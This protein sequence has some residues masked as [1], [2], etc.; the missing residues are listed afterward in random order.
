MMSTA[1]HEG[2]LNTPPLWEKEQ[3]GLPQFKFP[4]VVISNLKETQLPR[5]LRL[6]HQMEKVFQQLIH[7]TDSFDLVEHNI[8]VEAGRHRIGELDFIIQNKNT[9]Q[10]FHVEL[11]YKFYLIDPTI[12][13]PIYRLVGPNRRDMFYTKLD[14]LKEK[15][16][17]LLFHPSLTPLWETLEIDPLKIAQSCCFKAQLFAPLG[18]KPS[19]RP[20]NNACIAGTWIRFDVFNTERFRSASYHMPRKLEW[21]L[22]PHLEVP[23]RSHYEILLD[24]NLRMVAKNAP[25]LWMKTP[26][27]ALSRLFVVW[28]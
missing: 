24:V 22:S 23:W 18:E 26:S 5:N 19:I 3:F 14:K 21:V 17:P 16:L 11:V 9:H 28:W 1:Y 8:L 12:S 2:F 6:G 15:Q 7:S 13:E 10:Y 27:G 4:P 20:L 25:M